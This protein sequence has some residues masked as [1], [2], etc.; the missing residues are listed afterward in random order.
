[1]NVDGA[2]IPNPLVITDRMVEGGAIVYGENKRGDEAKAG[3]ELLKSGTVD[4]TGLDKEIDKVVWRFTN[5]FPGCLIK[6][7]DGIRAK[8]K[9]FW[10][11]TKLANRHWLAANMGGEALLG[12]TAFNN[13]KLTGEDVIDFVKFRQMIAE[14]AIMDDEAFA[15][16]LP[17][18]K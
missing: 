12:F 9:F 1:L 10:D 2:I 11:Q 5:L 16:V 3:K 8:K 18:A 13:R 4:F 14:G 6:S 7:I 17:K 15:G